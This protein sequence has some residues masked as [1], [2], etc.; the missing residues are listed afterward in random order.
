[1]T[2]TQKRGKLP[3]KYCSYCGREMSLDM[4]NADENMMFYGDQST[5]PYA[6]KYNKKTGERQY[7]PYFKCPD[8]KNKKWYQIGG[9][10]HDEYFLDEVWIEKK[11]GI[12]ELKS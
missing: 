7:C 5:I 6:S 1:M 9:S 4:R 8:H 10:P 2:N 12:W 3:T 11:F